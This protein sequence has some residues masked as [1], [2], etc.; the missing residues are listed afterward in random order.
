M[1]CFESLPGFSSPFPAKSIQIWLRLKLAAERLQDPRNSLVLVLDVSPQPHRLERKRL[2]QI[3]QPN[4]VLLRCQHPRGPY[5]AH[6]VP[7]AV[8]IVNPVSVVIG[9][10]N[11]GSEMQPSRFKSGKELPAARNAAESHNRPF[12]R[13][14]LHAPLQPPDRSSP[15]RCIQP[16]LHRGVARGDRDHR[17]ALHRTERLAKISRR[18][19]MIM[20]VHAVQQQ[21]IHIAF[22]LPML[23][24]IIEQMHSRARRIVQHGLSH[25]SRV[26]PLRSHID[27]HAS[28]ARN[29]QRFVAKLL[30]RAIR[31]DS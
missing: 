14:N 30:G 18:Q 24:A 5:A 4:T 1:W 8:Q 21:N 12:N 7:N 17:R 13:W 3:T 22:E 31:I 10:S 25:L 2:P 28:L 26:I 19:Q 15:T 23:K 6:R 11:P 20:Q 9:E 29:Q 16:G 27:R